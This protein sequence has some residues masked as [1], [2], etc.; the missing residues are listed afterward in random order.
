MPG[1]VVEAAHQRDESFCCSLARLQFPSL[2]CIQVPYA[3]GHGLPAGGDSAKLAPGQGRTSE[4][5]LMMYGA[6][7]TVGLTQGLTVAERLRC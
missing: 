5:T 1:R 6:T 7:V 4:A 2:G 3:R